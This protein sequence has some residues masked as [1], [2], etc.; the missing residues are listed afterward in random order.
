MDELDQDKLL[1]ALI[2]KNPNLTHIN[3]HLADFK[4]EPIGTCLF[5][6][7][8]IEDFESVKTRNTLIQGYLLCLLETELCN[9]HEYNV[10]MNA[11]KYIHES[12]TKKE[13]DFASSDPY[14]PD[15]FFITEEPDPNEPS[16]EIETISI[17]RH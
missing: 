14:N 15:N 6:G 12:K 10:F 11:L 5:M 1:T 16:V 17:T 7:L 8:P 13:Q 4:S 9:E 2:Q 3:K